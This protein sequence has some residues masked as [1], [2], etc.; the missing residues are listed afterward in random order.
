MISN[1]ILQLELKCTWG[2]H[3]AETQLAAYLTAHV[4]CHEHHLLDDHMCA[5][6]ACAQQNR[7]VC[8]VECEDAQH[9][10]QVW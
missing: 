6:T 4:S 1:T 7:M 5:L 2:L 10:L 9:L 3:G 8:R